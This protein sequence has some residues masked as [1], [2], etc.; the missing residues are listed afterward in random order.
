MPTSGSW[1]SLLAQTVKR[2]STM[3]ETWVRSLGWEDSLEKEITTHS[4]TPALKIPWTEELDAGYYP[5]GHKES[6]TTERLHFLSFWFLGQ[7]EASGK[8]ASG[9]WNRVGCAWATT[10]GL[11]SHWSFLLMHHTHTLLDS[12]TFS[13]LELLDSFL[14]F[15]F[16]EHLE[17]VHILLS[18]YISTDSLGDYFPSTLSPVFIVCWILTTA[19]VCGGIWFPDFHFDWHSCS[20]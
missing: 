18:V 7:A 15:F 8:S 10:E 11:V 3:W 13:T 4:S 5:W 20:R 17:T 19:I 14:F 12:I 2:L 16:F 6:G 9:L 1:T